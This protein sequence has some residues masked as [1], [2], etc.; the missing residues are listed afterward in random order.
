MASAL[1]SLGYSEVNTLSNGNPYGPKLGPSKTLAG[2]SPQ[3]PKHFYDYLRTDAEEPLL[4]DEN[5]YQYTSPE[6]DILDQ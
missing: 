1:D 4:F 5:I 2:Q 3:M 6:H